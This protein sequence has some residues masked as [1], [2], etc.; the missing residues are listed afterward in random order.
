MMDLDD[1]GNLIDSIICSI[2]RLLVLTQR[3][4]ISLVE[5]EKSKKDLSQG[6][7]SGR[8][9]V[10]SKTSKRQARIKALSPKVKRDEILEVRKVKSKSQSIEINKLYI[11]IIF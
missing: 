4:E 10:A 1:F 11:G 5:K 9:S 8:E 2:T 3:G 6:A 7:T